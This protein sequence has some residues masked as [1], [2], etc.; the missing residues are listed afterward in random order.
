MISKI[1]SPECYTKPLTYRSRKGVDDV[2][3]SDDPP[4][5]G[6]LAIAHHPDVFLS[7]EVDSL[8][9]DG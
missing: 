6:G 2:R 7:A 3:H 5:S 4:S 9:E 8:P 1:G